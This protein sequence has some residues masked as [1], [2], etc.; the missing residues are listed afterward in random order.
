MSLGNIAL[1]SLFIAALLTRSES[2]AN[3]S[4]LVFVIRFTYAILQVSR[5]SLIKSEKGEKVCNRG[6]RGRRKRTKEAGKPR[7]DEKKLAKEGQK[8]KKADNCECK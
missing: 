6:S 1:L 8:G 3:I 5:C 2:V 4:F 7:V